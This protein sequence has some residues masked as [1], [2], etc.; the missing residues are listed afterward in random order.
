M[1]K[2]IL[3]LIILLPIFLCC[4][5]SEQEKLVLNISSSE[6]YTTTRTFNNNI[7]CE[8]HLK[9]SGITNG[10]LLSIETYGDGVTG[11][12]EIKCDSDKK[13]NADVEICFLPL[14]DSIQR[15]F[16]T[17]LTAYSSKI[18]PNSPIFCDAVGSGETLRHEL[19]S[20]LLTCK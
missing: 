6:W 17:I 14:R 2:F 12:A 8:V 3:L 20:P 5:K 4:K 10:E 18:K 11:C 19:E 15:K 13:F 9:V 16:G 7:F 1:K